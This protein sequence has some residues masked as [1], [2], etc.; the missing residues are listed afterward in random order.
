MEPDHHEQEDIN[1]DWHRSGD[2]HLHACFIRE[3]PR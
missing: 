2:T 3:N 1:K